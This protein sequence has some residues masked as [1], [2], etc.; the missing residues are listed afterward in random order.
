MCKHDDG[1]TGWQIT[2][3]P[4]PR[5]AEKH[6]FRRQFA[7][8]TRANQSFRS[9]S[10]R[11]PMGPAVTVSQLFTHT[12]REARRLDEPVQPEAGLLGTRVQRSQLSPQAL[13]PT[14][15]PSVLQA[16]PKHLTYHTWARAVSEDVSSPSSTASPAPQSPS[17][18]SLASWRS[19][20]AS[21]P[22]SPQVARLAPLKGRALS[23]DSGFPSSFARTP[24]SDGDKEECLLPATRLHFAFQIL[25]SLAKV[26]VL[27]R[28]GCGGILAGAKAG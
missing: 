25:S 23:M 8:E 16:K 2:A 1:S 9:E 22:R 10:L 24:S 19:S 12:D 20:P 27:E 4:Q 5:S 13:S 17:A 6:Q 7:P 3:P 26:S 11:L 28:G 18:V 15:S 14:S 21:P